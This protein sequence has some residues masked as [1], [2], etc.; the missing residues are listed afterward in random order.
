MSNGFVTWW[1]GLPE[2]MDPVIFSIGSFSIQYYGLMYL[3]AFLIVGFLAWSR[4]K[5]EGRFPINSEQLQSLM[6]AMIL[7]VLIGGRLGYVLF[8]NP[9]HYL[10][11]PLEI[12]NPFR[13][14]GGF[15]FTGISGM[16]YHGGVIGVIVGAIVYC[17]QQK[18]DFFLMGD[19]IG[20]CIPLGYMFGRLGN[21]INGELWGRPTE[22]A[23]GMHFPLA[24][25][26]LRH[27]SQLYEA[28]FEGIFLFV[29]LWLLRK[30]VKTKGAMLTFYLTGYGL[31]RFFVEYTRE[32]DAHLGFVLG[33]LS[34]GQVL[35]L[36]MIFGG[37]GMYLLLRRKEAQDRLKAQT[38]KRKK[39]RS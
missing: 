17:R 30:R 39:S 8:Y 3:V 10:T 4:V 34:M 7:G 24:G 25:E 26:G 15:Q 6:T 27:P 23:I 20:P 9:M 14:S 36:L 28:F 12:I 11:H 1:Q 16:S 37:I 32:P 19:L 38:K 29:I 21:F 35:C 33:S 5:K 18:L 31:V 13:T 22:A 2:R